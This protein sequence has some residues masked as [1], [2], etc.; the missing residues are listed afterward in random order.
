MQRTA[1]LES[2]GGPPL[3]GPVLDGRPPLLYNNGRVSAAAGDPGGQDLVQE[4][5]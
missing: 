1:P 3:A 5:G 4:M 2:H